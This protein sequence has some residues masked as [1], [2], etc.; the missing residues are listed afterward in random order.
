MTIGEKIELSLIPVLGIGF[1][2]IAPE[3]PDQLGVGRL[4]LAASALLLLQSLVRDLWLLTR[5]KR[6]SQPGPRRAVRCMCI[7]STVGATGI[8]VG[9][10]LLGSG[11]TRL[12]AMDDWVWSVLVMLILG[13]G[14]VT[15]DYVLEW[16]P[17]RIRRDKDHMNIVFTWKT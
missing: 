5:K 11:I 16:S 8:V 13:V 3:L 2:V 14:F 10:I 4:L 1:W 17:W 15:K 9:A 12:I 6:A 7:E